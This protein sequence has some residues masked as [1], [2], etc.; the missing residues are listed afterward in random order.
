MDAS[1]TLAL[2]SASKFVFTLPRSIR[3]IQREA[4]HPPSVDHERHLRTGHAQM[5]DFNSS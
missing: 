3:N 5:M 2:S 1:K 4:K